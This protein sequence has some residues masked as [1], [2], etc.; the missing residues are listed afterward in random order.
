MQVQQ[1]K[2]ESQNKNKNKMEIME[3]RINGMK[4]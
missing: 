2:K 4:V 3:G 1:N